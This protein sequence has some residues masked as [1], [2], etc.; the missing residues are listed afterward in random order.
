MKDI[1]G[2]DEH[3]KEVI[4]AMCYQTSKEI[5]AM[6]TVLE[7]RVDAIILIG[8]MA[9]VAFICDEIKKRT[10]WIAPVEVMPGE[11]EMIALAEGSYKA[12]N[13]EIPT[14]E[15]IPKNV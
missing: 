10:A 6:A 11:R 14:K 13:G 7:G 9:N 3:A 2:G 15:F 8:G 12:L 5:G 1:E 4:Q